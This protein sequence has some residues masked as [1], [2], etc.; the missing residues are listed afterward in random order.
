MGQFGTNLREVDARGRTLS[1]EIFLDSKVGNNLFTS[2]DLKSHQAAH[3][4]LNNRKGAVVAIDIKDGSI[5]TLF[6][7]PTFSTNQLV[8]GILQKDFDELLLSEEKP[9]FNRALKGRY[10]PASSINPAIAMFGIEQGLIDWNY[11]IYD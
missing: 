9:F 7:S 10:P 11:S 5:V 6:S 3:K 4:A 1:E 2:L 8:N